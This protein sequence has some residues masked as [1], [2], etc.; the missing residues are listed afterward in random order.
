MKRERRQ[1]GAEGSRSSRSLGPAPPPPGA[2][3][4]GHRYSGGGDVSARISGFIKEEKR[5]GMDERYVSQL[6]AGVFL[7][8]ILTSFS[9]F[10]EDR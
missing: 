1:G 6:V 5:R 9:W 8:T 3:R 7:A 4:R 10:D 2:S